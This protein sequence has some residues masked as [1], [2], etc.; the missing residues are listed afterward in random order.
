MKPINRVQIGTQV[1][2]ELLNRSGEREKLTFDLVA[3]HQADIQNGFLGVSTHLAKTILGESTGILIPYFTAEYQAV[4]LLSITAST[5]KP[6]SDA[7]AHREANLQAAKDQIEFTNA[8]LFA[9][10]ADTKWGGYDADGLDF[11]HWQTKKSTD[12]GD[13]G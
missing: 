3:D 11:E 10:S 6:Q 5:R 9:S 13:T 12:E 1:E 4:E 8:V 7:A 2:L